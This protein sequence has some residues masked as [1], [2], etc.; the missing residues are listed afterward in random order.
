[1][2]I[3]VQTMIR[4]EVWSD[5]QC[6][7]GKR[8]AVLGPGDLSTC[9]ATATITGE[10]RLTFSMGAMVEGADAVLKQRVLR[11]VE[12]DTTFDE[13]RIIDVSR[14]TQAA[15]VAGTAMPVDFDLA[16]GGMIAQTDGDKVVRFDFEA[17]GLLASV[18]IDTFVLP[19]LAAAGRTWVSRGTLSVDQPIDLAFA[20]DTALAVCKRIAGMQATE[21]QVRRVGTTGYTIDLLTA[22][23]AAAPV[24]DLRYTKNLP[25]LTSHESMVGVAT[26]V[27][28]RGAKD[29]DFSAT[30]ATARW[31]VTNV[32]GAVVTLADPSGGDGP[33]AFSG[34][35][36]GAYLQKADGTRTLVSASSAGGQTVTVASATGIATG[37]LI[38]F[39][40][41]SAGTDLT[42]LDSPSDVAALGV[43][44]GVLDVPDVP[45]TENVIP[46]PV[47]RDWPAGTLPTGW[48]PINAPTTSKNTTPSFISTGNA[49]IHVVATASGQGVR[50]PA[51]KVAPTAL[52]PYGS[53]YGRIWIVSGAV[54]AEL[55]VTKADATTVILPLSPSVASSSKLGQWVDLGISGENLLP[56]S[57]V[58]IAV[59][60]V[61]HGGAAEFYVDAAQATA[62]A[63]QL[64]FVEG[65]GGTKLWQA[66]NNQLVKQGGA[67]VTLDATI[68]DLARID[69]A[70]WGDDTAIVQ[71]GTVR[72]TDGRL[73]PNTPANQLSDVTAAMATDS[74]ADGVVDGWT[75][76]NVG[77]QS[78]SWSYDATDK[79]QRIDATTP[80]PNSAYVRAQAHVIIQGVNA[81]DIVTAKAGGRLTITSGAMRAVLVGAALSN[82]GANLGEASSALLGNGSAY[83]DLQMTPFVMPAGTTQFRFE[84]RLDSNGVGQG[85]AW[86]RSATIK[87]INRAGVVTTR[88]IQFERDYITPGKSTVTLSS[89]FDDLVGSIARK[90][91]PGR[92]AAAVVDPSDPDFASTGTD[93]LPPPKYRAAPSVDIAVKS[94]GTYQYT[95]RL[96]ARDPDGEQVTLRWRTSPTSSPSELTTAASA[97]ASDGPHPTPYAVDLPAIDRDTSDRYIEVWAEDESGNVSFIARELI[98]AMSSSDMESALSSGVASGAFVGTCPTRNL[99]DTIT[100][101][102]AVP[103]WVVNLYQGNGTGNPTVSAG[104]NIASGFTVVQLTGVTNPP[105]LTGTCDRDYKLQIVN[106]YGHVVDE[107]ILAPLSTDYKSC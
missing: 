38:G 13:W 106:S 32:A 60:V 91:R 54:R 6:A 4:A 105:I 89:K 16:V 37:D 86:F 88:V 43:V 72:L 71:G 78:A 9:I 58:A 21:L 82:V 8:L 77:M 14:D 81:G 66:A 92:G 102:K 67:I 46:N 70:S 62:S 56:L 31:T 33:I 93:K 29:G 96:T 27:F 48:T 51:G 65:S 76:L 28:P 83:T 24:A 40:A 36:V 30:M 69:P 80:N 39:R 61:A 18:H 41:D 42:S 23:G 3:T 97:T 104:S 22:M 64:P 98:P 63:S 5:Y 52:R 107:D 25:G 53:G 85:S 79:A 75:S 87:I 15:S 95:F 73:A 90:K 12:D 68:V 2:L 103:S 59:R 10:D 17:L 44:A 7:G 74:N 19:A 50:S 84:C 45:E 55:V 11:I 1:M 99:V 94:T 100:F 35:L 47:G 101:T 34:Q 20:W 49:S 57:A 26:R